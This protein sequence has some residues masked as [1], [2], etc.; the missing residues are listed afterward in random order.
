LSAR[1]G[2]H[3]GAPK[4]DAKEQGRQRFLSEKERGE[5]KAE[6][7]R[8]DIPDKGQDAQADTDARHHE[9]GASPHVTQHT[10]LL[11]HT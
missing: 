9:R 8:R 3:G 10:T 1:R 11:R 4:G 6:N 5:E 2:P 7:K